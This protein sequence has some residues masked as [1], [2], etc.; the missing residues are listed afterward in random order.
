MTLS[1]WPGPDAS[2][3]MWAC[4]GA[5]PPTFRTDDEL[6]PHTAPDHPRFTR[7][8]HSS[9]PSSVMHCND[10]FMLY[11]RLASHKLVFSTQDRV[12]RWD[13]RGGLQD[14]NQN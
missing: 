5:A 6:S 9:P 1:I 2:G 12:V 4:G 11:L 14:T 8:P 7:P 10:I 13:L 3:H